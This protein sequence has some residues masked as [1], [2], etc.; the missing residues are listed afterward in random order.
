MPTGT[1][2]ISPLDTLN[3]VCLTGK[4]LGMILT[5]LSNL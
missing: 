2:K 4:V 5:F 3:Q 1:H